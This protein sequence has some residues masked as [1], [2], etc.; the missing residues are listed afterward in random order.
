MAFQPTV[1]I[2][3][4]MTT[5]QIPQEHWQQLCRHL[6]TCYAQPDLDAVSIALASAISHYTLDNKPVWI[7]ILGA[8]STGKTELFINSIKCL[9]Y[10]LELSSL[11]EASFLSRYDDRAGILPNLPGNNHGILCFP[12]FSNFLGLDSSVRQTL[13]GQMREIYDGKFQK[14][15]GN[16]PD[17][18]VWQG[19][20]TMIIACTPD[21]DRYWSLENS[22]GDR[23]FMLRINEPSQT[24][25]ANVLKY[26]QDRQ[27]TSKQIIET[28]QQLVK[29]FVDLPNYRFKMLPGPANLQQYLVALG[30]LTVILRRGVVR[31][32]K[33]AISDLKETESPTRYIGMASTLA[34]TH[35]CMFRQEKLELTQIRLIRRMF[36]QTT[37]PFR[38]N[39]LYHLY[40]LPHAISITEFKQNYCANLSYTMLNRVFHD[41]EVIGLIKA[42]TM[43]KSKF[44]KLT[45]MAYDVLTAARIQQQKLEFQKLED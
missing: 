7:F 30:N 3:V 14:S 22:L 38:L 41:L 9:P 1:A 18:I 31:D 28:T 12:D 33:G 17:P 32:N 39:L 34:H 4:G 44:W 37:Q 20:V 35:A 25:L 19:K 16:R 43:G 6:T 2:P 40:C 13:Q 42:N 36:L 10:T 23:F 11:T 26:R 5:N 27:L 8:S 24:N 29:Q 15:A 21:L 45:D